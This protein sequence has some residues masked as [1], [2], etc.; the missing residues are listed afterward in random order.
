MTH[1][2]FR[3]WKHGVLLDRLLF[4]LRY[5]HSLLHFGLPFSP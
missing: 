5:L 2:E 4:L 3:Q 1:P